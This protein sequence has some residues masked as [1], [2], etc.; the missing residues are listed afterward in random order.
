MEIEKMGVGIARCKVT[1]D[2]AEFTLLSGSSPSA[3]TVSVKAKSAVSG[4]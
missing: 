2:A 4:G 1:N 3:S